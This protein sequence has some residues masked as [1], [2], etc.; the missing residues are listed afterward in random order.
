[1]RDDAELEGLYRFLNNP[2][3][4]WESILD[5]HQGATYKRIDESPT[6][7]ILHDTTAFEFDGR[8]RTALGYL[9]TG[10]RGF[11]AH[12]SLSV[13][14]GQQAPRALGVP[15]MHL[16]SRKDK[17]RKRPKRGANPKL[18]YENK[19]SKESSRWI[20]Q[21]MEV[22]SR[23]QDSDSVIHVMDREADSYALIAEMQQHDIPFVTR[24][25]YDRIMENE[26]AEGWEPLSHA[27]DGA[28]VRC[29]REAPLSRR[30]GS[31]APRRKKTHPARKKRTAKLEI[32]ALSVRL[33]RAARLGDPHPKSL[34]VNVV[35]VLEPSPPEGQHPVSWQLV[36][37]QAVDTE[38]QVL[39]I[40]D[41]Y[42]TR[43]QIEEFFKALKTGCAYKRRQ[44]EDY[45]AL[46]NTLALL[47]PLAW[48][49]LLLRNEARAFPDNSAAT[50]LSPRQIDV[51]RRMTKKGLPQ[52]PTLADALYAIAT[53]G[54]HVGK[55]RPPGLLTIGRGLEKLLW[56]EYG[57]ALAKQGEKM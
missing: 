2:K 42:R 44:I 24:L 37:N 6:V 40:V 22:H 20:D 56:V 15:A 49:L 30:R 33:R 47:V 36:T 52:S 27:L 7:A 1:M 48:Q 45:Q 21:I 25:R 4:T 28:V 32:R 23:I 13:G 57:F 9:P 34:Q 26:E 51:L 12:I 18:K 19:E 35:Q 55:S 17:P 38:K 53:E 46:Q 41:I 11:F 8:E 10:R 29:R 3:V 5:P 31:S 54:G 14:L 16:F 50:V 43:W 39:R